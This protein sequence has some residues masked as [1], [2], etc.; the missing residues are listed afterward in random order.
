[1]IDSGEYVIKNIVLGGSVPLRL[2]ALTVIH[3]ENWETVSMFSTQEDTLP[4]RV[5]L[6]I[7]PQTSR[8]YDADSNNAIHL[9]ELQ[10]HD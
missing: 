5:E 8:L 1:M 10:L 3:V 4:G 9:A 2:P 6:R 7:S